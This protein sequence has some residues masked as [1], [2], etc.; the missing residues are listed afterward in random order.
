LINVG[1]VKVMGG[2]GSD[3]MAITLSMDQLLPS[4]GGGS[5]TFKFR[6]D[7]GAQASFKDF[8]EFRIFDWTNQVVLGVAE[9]PKNLKGASPAPPT[10]PTQPAQST[11]A[12]SSSAPTLDVGN[13]ASSPSGSTIGLN[14][15]LA[16]ILF[17]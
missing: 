16:Y 17:F 6:S 4:V 13:Q 14:F 10:N 9:V 11:S 5:Q 8:T 3:P 12:Q 7:A 2:N 15:L 1:E